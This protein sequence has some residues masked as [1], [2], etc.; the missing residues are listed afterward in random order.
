MPPP[1]GTG[2]LLGSWKENARSSAGDRPLTSVIGWPSTSMPT[3][4]TITAPLTRGSVSRAI[5]AASQPPKELPIT[6][7]SVRSSSSSSATY[8]RARSADAG[9]AVG[10]RR[11][12]E[13]GVGG[14]QHPGVG[15]FGEQ[16]GEPGHRG[17][18]TAAVQ[19]QERPGA[20]E[21]L[22]V[23]PDRAEGVGFGAG[24]RRLPAVGSVVMVPSRASMGLI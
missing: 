9:Q 8:G 1:G 15:A 14:Q 5:S 24:G 11:A 21:V 17:D 3:P 2:A 12:V 10:F 23:S 6:V 16:V 20:V 4:S 22:E 7:T 18:T 19:E 13:A